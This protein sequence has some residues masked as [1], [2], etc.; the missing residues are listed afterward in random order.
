MAA[1]SAAS[2]E[3]AITGHFSFD[4]TNRVGGV[5]TIHGYLKSLEVDTLVAFLSVPFA[6]LDLADHAGVHECISF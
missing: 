2:K 3:I 5:I 1:A 6:L 4:Q